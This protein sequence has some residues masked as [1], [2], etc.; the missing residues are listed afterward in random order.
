MTIQ[1]LSKRLHSVTN[2][3]TLKKVHTGKFEY[4]HQVGVYL[5]E[6]WYRCTLWPTSVIGLINVFSIYNFENTL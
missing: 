5:Y 3:L 2:C 4:F 6:H 1:S